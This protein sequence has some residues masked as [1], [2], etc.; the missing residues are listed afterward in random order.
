MSLLKRLK[1]RKRRKTLRVRSAQQSRGEKLRISVYRSLNHIYAQIIDD[2]KGNTLASCSSKVLVDTKG[3]KT[4]IAKQVGLALGKIAVSKNLSN[5][6]FDRGGALYHG[7][8]QAVADGLREAGL[9]F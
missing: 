4:E 9:S 5:V 7:R 3:T 2:S 1:A 6:F 8:V